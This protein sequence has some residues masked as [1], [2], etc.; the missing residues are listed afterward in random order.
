MYELI[1][2]DRFLLFHSSL[3]SHSSAFCIFVTSSSSSAQKRG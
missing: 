1:R 2:L 3:A